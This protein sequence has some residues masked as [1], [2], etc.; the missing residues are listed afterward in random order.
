M[1]ALR[2]FTSAQRGQWASHSAAADLE[3]MGVDHGGGHIG[4]AQQFL[5]RSD[6]TAAL[7]QMRGEAVPKRVWRCRLGDTSYLHGSLECA[8]ESLV[9]KVM[10]AHH[11]ASRVRRVHGLREQPEP[12]PRRPGARVLALQRVR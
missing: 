2:R 6:V 7:K 10:A 8:L 4:V 9:V 5:H 1:T 12:G 11:A 3:H